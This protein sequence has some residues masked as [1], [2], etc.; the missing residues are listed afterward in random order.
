VKRSKPKRVVT[1]NYRVS[2]GV[3]LAKEITKRLG[4]P[5]I[6]MPK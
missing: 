3:T 4:I 6:A 5:A 1:D 2:H